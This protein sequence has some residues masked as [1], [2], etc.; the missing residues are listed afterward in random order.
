MTKAQ[1]IVRMLTDKRNGVWREPEGKPPY[2]ENLRCPLCQKH[3]MKVMVG[4]RKNT[5][6]VFCTQCHAKGNPLINAIREETGIWLAP[7]PRR[8]PPQKLVAQ[9]RRSPEYEVL[10]PRSKALVDHLVKAYFGGEPNGGIGGTGTEL[11]AVIGTHSWKHLYKAINAAIDAKIVLRGSR[12]LSHGKHHGSSNLWGLACLPREH[13]KRSRRNSTEQGRGGRKWGE[14]VD[15]GGERGVQ[16]LDP[17]RGG[18]A[19]VY[20]PSGQCA[21]ERSREKA[22]PERAARVRSPGKETN[23][24]GA[25]GRVVGRSPPS[26]RLCRYDCAKAGECVEPGGVCVKRRLAAC[27]SPAGARRR[28]VSARGRASEWR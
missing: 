11:M 18:C 23:G 7:K 12:A 22:K 26:S 14:K 6:V 27:L 21:S 28:P 4:D 15:L 1:T 25:S 5:P 8:V 10:P 19:V 2:G 16:P 20:D 3:G 13:P 9:M 24:G 17:A